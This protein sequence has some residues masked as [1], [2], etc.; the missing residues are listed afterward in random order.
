MTS[1]L[2]LQLLLQLLL[3]SCSSEKVDKRAHDGFTIYLMVRAQR[4]RH[5]VSRLMLTLLW[6]VFRYSR[7]R[8]AHVL[9][10][11]GHW[12]G[13]VLKQERRQTERAYVGPDRRHHLALG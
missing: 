11:I 13:P 7:T 5:Y 1:W 12:H 2:L 6:P 8:D 9:R 4:P 3:S 10:L